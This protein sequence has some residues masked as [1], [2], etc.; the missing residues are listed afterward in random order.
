LLGKF[1]EARLLGAEQAARAEPL[2]RQVLKSAPDFAWAHLALA[3][4][5]A[6]DEKWSDEVETHVRAFR[7]LCP[8]SLAAASLY[9]HVA[10]HSYR[11]ELRTELERLLEPRSDE[12]ALALY[13]TLW[14]LRSKVWGLGRM[15]LVYTIRRDLDRLRALDRPSS[16]MWAKT[17]LDGDGLI[18]DQESIA[19]LKARLARAK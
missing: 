15:G 12:K 19:S 6:P 3:Q 1:L 14:R 17:L 9:E 2:L 11:Y 10:S 5:L 8:A 4:L 7:K 16:P 18:E 13:P